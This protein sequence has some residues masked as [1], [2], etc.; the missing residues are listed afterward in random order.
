MLKCHFI[1]QREYM[2]L[3]AK[4]ND[5]EKEGRY[6]NSRFVIPKDTYVIAAYLKVDEVSVLPEE[7]QI[8]QCIEY[9]NS[10][11]IKKRN[12]VPKYGN[13]SLYSWQRKNDEY[14]VLLLTKNKKNPCFWGVGE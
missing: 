3:N 9:L 6:H 1:P 14:I 10:I 2:F 5:I 11:V 12:P 4:E 8:K 13:L 7:E